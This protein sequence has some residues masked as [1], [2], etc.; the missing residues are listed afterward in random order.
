[1]TTSRVPAVI[2]ALVAL[3]KN[4]PG[5]AKVSVVDGP[6][7][8]NNPL[9][10]AVFIGYDGDPDGEGQAAED[11]QTWAGIGARSRDETIQITGAVVVWRGSTKVRPVRQ[12]AYELFGVVEDVL[13]ADPSIGLPPPTVAE[14]ASG[15]L[16]QA[17]RQSGIEARV[18]FLIKVQTRI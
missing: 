6:P 16:Y 2:D 13:R 4:A 9:H 17:Q 14:I 12:R 7:V 5:L 18:P 3:Y 8:T 15:G 11:A 10:E 1:M